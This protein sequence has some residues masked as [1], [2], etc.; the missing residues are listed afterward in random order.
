MKYLIWMTETAGFA[1][2]ATVELL[3]VFGSGEAV[4]R[5]SEREIAACCALK[6][7]QKQALAN[8]DLRRAEAILGECRRQNIQVLTILDEAYPQRLKNIFDPPVVL[9]IRGRLPDF[10]RL[11]AIA[12]VGQRKATPYG[13][14]AAEELGYH[15]SRRGVVVVS[16]MAEGAD[17][18]AH[19][20]A[21]KGGT[22]TVAVFGTAIDGCYPGFH[23]GLLRQI[24]DRG[25]A[26][27]EYPPGKRGYPSWF[28]RRNRIISGLCLGTVITEAPKRSGSLITASLALDQGRDV[29]A[30]PANID[31]PASAGSN[32]LIQH[33]A[34]L[35]RTA[36]DILEEYAGLYPFRPD[37]RPA[38]ATRPGAMG[39]QVAPPAGAPTPTPARDLSGVFHPAA[40]TPEDPLLAA[41][42]G[43]TPLDT[44]L[45]RTGLTMNQALAKLTLLEL[46]GVVRQLPGKQ[47]EKL[48]A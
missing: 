36:E 29:F 46:Q 32:E 19:R 30:V 8:R 43:V 17:G 3:K 27:S 33:G 44:I 16:G 18:A 23:G 13:L 22:P 31:A 5:A 38:G 6:E 10:N 7:R 9:Y 4:F 37:E 14:R 11:P 47:F 15:L 2:E 26:V 24:L 25:A 39:R 42:H 48:Q 35:V 41:I 34:K 1:P 12:L 28:P 45:E 40:Q 20:G 21:L